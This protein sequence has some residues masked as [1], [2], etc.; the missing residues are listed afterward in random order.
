MLW[1]FV[2]NRGMLEKQFASWHE[3]KTLNK[4]ICNHDKKVAMEN[5][6]MPWIPG[7]ENM[8]KIF[9]VFTPRTA[10]LP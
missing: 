5:K 7:A 9:V 4:Q 3:N 2:L 1:F 8:I 6:W 10:C